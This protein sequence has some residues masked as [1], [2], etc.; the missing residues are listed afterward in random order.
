[1][2]Y[3][4]FTNALHQ[5]I[6]PIAEKIIG[7]YHCGFRRD[8]STINQCFILSQIFEEHHEY[9]YGLHNLFIDFR[10]AFDSINRAKITATLTKLGISQ[11]LI[12][13]IAMTLK[14]AKAK[15]LIREKL[16][17]TFDIVSGVKQG[18]ALST[19]VFNIMLHSIL[20]EIN[21]RATIATKLVQ[22]C[23]YADNVAIVARNLEELKNTFRKMSKIADKIG[24]RVNTV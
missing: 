6:E 22:I 20:K 18:D 14:N 8:R 15:V 12:R 4:I 3:K 19:L 21:T 13:L 10:Q 9:S 5:I 1:M 7:E 17:E 24:L 16:T 23:A 11:K 2:V